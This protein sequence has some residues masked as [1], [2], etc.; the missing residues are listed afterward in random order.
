MFDLSN[1][2]KCFIVRTIGHQSRIYGFTHYPMSLQKPSDWPRGSPCWMNRLWTINYRRTT[3]QTPRRNHKLMNRHPVGGDE[4]FIHSLTHLPLSLFLSS[5]SSCSRPT[6]CSSSAYAFR[7]R[8]S[9]YSAPRQNI[10]G[11]PPSSKGMRFILVAHVANRLHI[12]TFSKSKFDF[13]YYDWFL[14]LCVLRL[15]FWLFCSFIFTLNSFFLC[16]SGKIHPSWL[17]IIMYSFVI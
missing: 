2:F 3:V 5:P 12:K 16:W 13:F 17:N 15:S 7:S 4:S 8:R 9:F 6:V 10:F 14:C 11:S 1:P